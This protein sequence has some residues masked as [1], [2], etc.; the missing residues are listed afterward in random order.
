MWTSPQIIRLLLRCGVVA[1][2]LFVAVFLVE[3]ATR[4]AYSP[5][6]HPVSSLALG[7]DGWMQV[8]NFAIAGAEISH[9]RAARFGDPEPVQSEETDQR[10]RVAALV[11]GGARYQPTLRIVDRATSPPRFR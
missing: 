2:P 8:A 10:I 9:V 4:A 7:V 6:R 3:G 11:F 1:G 5:L